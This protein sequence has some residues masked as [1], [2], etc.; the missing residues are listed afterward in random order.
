MERRRNKKIKSWSQSTL[1]EGSAW[2]YIN[3]CKKWS[4]YSK[5]GH[6]IGSALNG[7]SFLEHGHSNY[8]KL[9]DL[10][11]FFHLVTVEVKHFYHPLLQMCSRG[12][13]TTLTP[14][15][16][17][18][19]VLACNSTAGESTPLPPHR[20]EWELLTS[21]HEGTSVTITFPRCCGVGVVYPWVCG[22]P[23]HTG[24][25]TT[26]CVVSSPVNQKYCGTGT[27]NWFDYDL[28]S[29]KA[30]TKTLLP[31]VTGSD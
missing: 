20:T 17:W 6:S 26:H 19:F 4:E 24:W 30:A 25:R 28:P 9:T 21:C 27:G 31:L 2:N 10:K 7:S 3:G 15:K 11:I 16:C 5:L 12:F 8:Q 18:S 22:F 13:S 29:R 1:K 14:G 23:E